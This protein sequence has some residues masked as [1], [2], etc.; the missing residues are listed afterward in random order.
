MKTRRCAVSLMVG[1]FLAVQCSWDSWASPLVM[2]PHERRSVKVVQDGRIKRIV[3][4]DM[5][6]QGV[7]AAIVE[8]EDG[9]NLIDNGGVKTK[10]IPFAKPYGKG[11]VTELRFSA[12]HDYFAVHTSQGEE[13][14]L[15]KSDGIAVYDSAGN[16][17]WEAKAQ[18]GTYYVAP[19][20]E[21]AVC[22]F[23]GTGS[24][25]YPPAFTNKSGLMNPDVIDR[26][27]L[28]SGKW[29][30]SS[31]SSLIAFSDDGSL[32][33]AGLYY[34]GQ[35]K[36]HVVLFD[37][38]GKLLFSLD[39][40]MG[41]SN[42]AFSPDKQYLAV[43]GMRKQQ[44]KFDGLLQV[45]SLNTKKPLWE[46][47]LPPAGYNLIF[48]NGSDRLLAVGGVSN[49]AYYFNSASGNVSWKFSNTES[50]D[51]IFENAAMKGK[52]ILLSGRGLKSRPQDVLFLLGPD[53]VVVNQKTFANGEIL[54]HAGEH[55]IFLRNGEFGAITVKGVQVFD[56][57]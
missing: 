49:V 54:K 8:N 53:G 38:T 3:V 30:P 4:P 18:Y 57:P 17:Q 6:G 41:V 50:N 15:G 10:S 16:K 26:S 52:F 9:V 33:A 22:Q 56:L 1:I 11:T 46:A 29:F 5:E 44:D 2:A 25:N 23:P 48:S 28:R 31:R 21:Y 24:P 13:G 12:K 36:G 20:G 7:P 55:Q 45:W 39:T 51:F 34:L 14:R 35:Q 19:N 47:Q 43:E 37:S 40:P 27:F 42:I 32:V